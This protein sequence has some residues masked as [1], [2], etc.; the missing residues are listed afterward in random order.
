MN[1]QD[2]LYAACVFVVG[3]FMYLTARTED[4]FL[5]IFWFGVFMFVT[6]VNFSIGDNDE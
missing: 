6:I 3:I 2:W 5:Y 1:R 4:P